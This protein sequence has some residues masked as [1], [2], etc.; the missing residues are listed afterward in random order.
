MLLDIQDITNRLGLGMRRGQPL[1]P[2]FQILNFIAKLYISISI[3][4]K[5]S[6]QNPFRG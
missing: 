6:E 4:S 1:S 3:I 2:G 5:K